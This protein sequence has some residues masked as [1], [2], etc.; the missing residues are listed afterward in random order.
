[1]R[2]FLPEQCRAARGLLNWT[3]EKLAE[4]AFVSR[5]TVRNFESGRHELSRGSEKLIV[6]A[7]EG[8]GVR[9]LSV[10]QDGPGVRLLLPSP[11]E[12]A[13]E[14]KGASGLTGAKES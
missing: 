5:S 1:M 9:I 4:A 2:T 10:D 3:Q 14:K 6:I 8:A 13:M 7:L 11:A 12:G